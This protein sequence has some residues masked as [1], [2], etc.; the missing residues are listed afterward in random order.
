MWAETLGYRDSRLPYLKE[1]FAEVAD[2]THL[3]GKDLLDLGCGP[4]EVALGLAPYAKAVTALD[5]EQ[6]MLD[7]LARRAGTAGH[8]IRM[9]HARAE[10]APLDLGQFT[11][12]TTGMS[13]SF[14]YSPGTF[15]RLER[16][17]LPGGRI[18]LFANTGDPTEDWAKIFHTIRR[19]HARA[20]LRMLK[21]IEPEDFFSGTGFVPD[22]ML[23]TAGRHKVTLEQLLHRALAYSSSTP[24]ALGEAAIRQMLAEL[25]SALAPYFRDG[26]VTEDFYNEGAFFRRM[27]DD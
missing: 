25:G 5:A 8:E 15:E 17:L 7:E 2:V 18:A 9:V 6:P 19:T 21:V 12:I 10:E 1:F 26:P 27:G 3:A 13:H 14:M 11:L 23:R 20:D 4:G 22:G 16:W 24:A